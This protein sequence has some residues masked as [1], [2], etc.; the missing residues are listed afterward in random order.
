MPT[1]KL[2][3]NGLYSSL[4]YWSLIWTCFARASISAMQIKIS[5]IVVLRTIRFSFNARSNC[6]LVVT[7]AFRDK[8]IIQTSLKFYRDRSAKILS[9]LWRET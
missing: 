6:I 1:A 9:K 4:V 3:Q 8:L 7:G 2:V 5:A